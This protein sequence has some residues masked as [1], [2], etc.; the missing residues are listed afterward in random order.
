MTKPPKRIW[1]YRFPTGAMGSVFKKDERGTDT[2]AYIEY[3][4]V[5]K[6]SKRR[7]KLEDF[8]DLM[9]RRK[10]NHDAL[11]AKRRKAKSK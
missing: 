8:D 9:K 7:A 2:S 3:I 11:I 1:I 6:P 4:R 10:K 5:D